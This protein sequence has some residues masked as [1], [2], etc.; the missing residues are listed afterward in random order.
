MIRQAAKQQEKAQ[1]KAQRKAEKAEAERVAELAKNKMVNL[2]KLTSISSGGG[3]T[4]SKSDITC[5]RC[6]KKGHIQREC[7][8]S[9]SQKPRK[10]ERSEEDIPYRQSSDSKKRSRH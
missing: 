7:P 9:G 1:R 5:H 4:V 8:E 3:T 6:G 2:K 10:R